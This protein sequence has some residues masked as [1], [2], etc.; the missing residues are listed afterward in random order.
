MILAGIVQG[1]VT[2]SQ[3]QAN[4][5]DA[6]AARAAAARSQGD[7][8]QAVDLYVKG[9]ELNPSWQ[10]GWWSLGTISYGSDQYAQAIDALNHLI[11]LTPEAPA[12]LALRGLCE[13]ETGQ[14]PESLQDLEHGIA[15]GAANQPRNAQIVLYHEALLLTRLGRFEDA[16]AKYTDFVKHAPENPELAVAVGLAGLRLPL[17]PKDVEDGQREMA[18]RVGGAAITVMTGDLENGQKAFQAVFNQYPTTPNIH[19]F[20]GY[21][22]FAAHSDQAEPEFERETA[23]SP[24]SALAHAMLAWVREFQNDNAGALSEAAKAAADDPTLPFAQMVYG[25]ALV[26]TGDAEAGIPHLQSVLQTEPGNLEA[27]ISLVKAYSKLGR[28]DDARRERLLCLQMV[29]TSKRSAGAG[30]SANP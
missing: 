30:S 5:F 24:H 22:L 11:A 14:Y 1:G 15:L 6:V 7:M 16:V 2:E 28:N 8:A 12:A 17:L 25:R 20:D 9:V 26:E 21:L 3:G 23:I 19:Y 4:D 18:E 29:D 13:F 10:E 27:H